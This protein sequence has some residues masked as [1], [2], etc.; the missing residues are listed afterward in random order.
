MDIFIIIYLDDILIYSQ[1]KK[2]HKQHIYYVLKALQGS[3]LQVKLEKSIF[4]IYEVD[5]L[6]YIILDKGIRMDPE[7]VCA[8]EE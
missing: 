5:Y 8:I 3:D 4:Y 1:T 6:G 7:K 2:E